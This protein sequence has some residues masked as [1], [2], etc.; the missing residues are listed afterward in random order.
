LVSLFGWKLD[1]VKR[2]PDSELLALIARLLFPTMEPNRTPDGT[3]FLIDRSVDSNLE[4]V[5]AD[6]RAGHTDLRTQSTIGDVLERLTMVR[7]SMGLYSEF[8]L[9]KYSYVAV[10]TAREADPDVEARETGL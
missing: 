6:V 9:G 3:R 7:A 10:A 2:Q 8:E 4:A 1:R 5:L